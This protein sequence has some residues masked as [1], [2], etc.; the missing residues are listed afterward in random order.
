M[1]HKHT[2]TDSTKTDFPQIFTK[3]KPP[4]TLFNLAGVT[5]KST[6]YITES[7]FLHVPNTKKTFSNSCSRS[8]P[9]TENELVFQKIFFFEN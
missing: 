6:I 8:L 5:S 1:T 4:P 7:F 3:S 9:N 2:Q